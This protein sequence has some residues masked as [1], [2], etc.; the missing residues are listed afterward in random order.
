[1]TLVYNYILASAVI[2]WAA[3]QIIKTILHTIKLKR[4]NAQRLI[5]AG[6]MPSSHTSMVIA[7]VIST[8][9]ATG[10]ASTEFALA[11]IFSAIVIHDAMSV[12]HAAG[13]HS[14]EL[15]KIKRIF[16]DFKES[17]SYRQLWEIW[18]SEKLNQPYEEKDFQEYLGHTPLE[19][20]AGALLG[21]IIAFALPM[22]I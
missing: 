8:G 11:F 4:F 6:G 12:R 18:N 17:K 22:K 9:R 20:M 10:T 1:M 19:V 5:G 7:T 15:N 3:A 16:T 13:L 2:S 21:V 14:R